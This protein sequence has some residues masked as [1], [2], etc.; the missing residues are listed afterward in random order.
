MDNGEK[1]FIKSL[2]ALAGDAKIEYTSSQKRRLEAICERLTDMN[3]H[4][5]WHWMLKGANTTDFK[6]TKHNAMHIYLNTVKDLK[7]ELTPMEAA[8]EFH[9]ALHMSH[10]WS[11]HLLHNAY[12]M[13]L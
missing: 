12:A 10:I 7:W 13:V 2:P 4:A 8:Y 1:A 6:T 5:E 11:R 3:G 9:S